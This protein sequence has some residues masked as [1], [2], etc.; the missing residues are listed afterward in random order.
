MSYTVRLQQNSWPRAGM[1]P[2]VRPRVEGSMKGKTIQVGAVVVCLAAGLVQPQAAAEAQGQPQAKR[3]SATLSGD[4]EVPSV[5][6]PATGHFVAVIDE[7]SETIE[8]TLSFGD[9]NGAVRQA[10]IH[11]GQS[12]ANGGVMLWLC[13][14]AVNPGPAGTPACPSPGGSVSGTLEASDV[15][16]VGAG[17]QGIVAG[18]FAEAVAAIRKGLAYV[19]VHSATSTGG[20]IRGQVLPGNG[21]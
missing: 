9:L 18:E 17:A 10:H 2:A 4:H 5:S 13:G 12:F 14:T 6:S 19:N 16:A 7:D 15:I 21:R 20:E 3:F 11:F 1:S 8:Y